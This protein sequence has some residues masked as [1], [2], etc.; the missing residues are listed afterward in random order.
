M[1]EGKGHIG[2]GEGNGR[3]KGKRAAGER[4]WSEM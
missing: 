1:D 4:R 3:G 2:K